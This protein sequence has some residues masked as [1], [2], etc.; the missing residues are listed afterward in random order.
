MGKR[1]RIS[2]LDL[3]AKKVE[4]T[5]GEVTKRL[6]DEREDVIDLFCKT[7]MVSHAPKTVE[8]LRFLFDNC[9]LETTMLESDEKGGY[10]NSY[11]IK[12]REQVAK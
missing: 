8:E 1:K 11:R 6:F 5:I 12:L 4:E 3:K 2:K 7:F 10:R 9:E